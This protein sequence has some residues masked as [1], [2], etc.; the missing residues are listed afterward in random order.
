MFQN[1][2]PAIEF[3]KIY[4]TD[5][6]GMVKAPGRVN[7]I[8][9]HTDYNCGFVFPC[10][11]KLSTTVTFKLRDDCIARVRSQAYPGME[12]QFD[13]TGAIE[14]SDTP[15]MNYIRGVFYIL[16]DYGFQL[17]RGIDILVGSS[18]PEDGGLASSA[19]LSV[20]VAGAI[21]KS[22][23]LS[24]D[25]R[26]LALVA[27]RAENDFLGNQCGIMDQ[28]TAAYAAEDHL[29]LIDCKDYK[30]KPIRLPRELAIVIINSR[31]KR[32]LVESGYNDRRSECN[33]AA[34]AMGV[35]SLREAS[36]QMLDNSMDSMDNAAFL[37]ARHVITEN[38]RTVRTAEALTQGD[39]QLVYQLMYE[40]H[41]SMKND[42]ENSVPEVDALVEYCKESLAPN[43]VGAR[44]TG[45]GFGG[46]IVALCQNDDAKTLVRH[47]T[48]NY[49]Q[50]YGIQAPSYICRPSSA[51]KIAWNK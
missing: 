21:S 38:E 12:D 8:G 17:T 24:I 31:V 22:M 30:I 16:R 48:A 34:E 39:I 27:Q 46:S 49:L 13:V 47:V 45:G 23:N 37:R 50:Q 51:M 26:S 9:E 7:L 36:L 6:E 1:E 33:R 15:W 5:P 29:L 28:L 2:D 14:H 42:F 43:A 41:E 32:K 18:L 20:S 19:A 44:M 11:L 25:K 35:A 10:A 40:S 3:N 4:N